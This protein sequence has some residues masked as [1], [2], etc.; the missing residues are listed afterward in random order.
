MS[1]YD[2]DTDPPYP[3]AP[4]PAREGAEA[5]PLRE[6]LPR[7]ARA[8]TTDPGVGPPSAPTREGKPMAVV[9][10]PGSGRGLPVASAPAA[11]RP[12]DSVELLLE[13]M[14]GPRPDRTRTMPQTA[15]DAA[16]AYHTEHAVRA[17]RSSREESDKKVLVET[18]RV[19][20]VSGPTQPGDPERRGDPTRV[21]PA[22]LGPRI[23]VAVLAGLAVA[24]TLFV[25]LE[26]APAQG[27]PVAAP[28]GPPAAL[29]P[30]PA[31]VAATS[32]APWRTEPPPEAVEPP[33]A[34]SPASS[35]AASPA[36]ATRP[37]A[38]PKSGSTDVGEFKTSF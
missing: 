23:A 35:T 21:L 19:P 28:A 14:A 29:A 27:A 5:S 6:P 9:V 17:G 12:K 36:V 18:L 4:P 31:P 33:P 34:P 38:R 2:Q 1:I 10:P 13:G 26:R 22:R 30:P 8:A 32:E 20:I 16:A 25:A 3:E 11:D 37:R 24:G 15:G 7:S